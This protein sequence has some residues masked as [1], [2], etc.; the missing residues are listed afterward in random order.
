MSDDEWKKRHVWY[1]FKFPKN[2]KNGRTRRWDK[3]ALYKTFSKRKR[4]ELI[5][6]NQV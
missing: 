3:I 2:N 1:F 5:G 4:N 6:S